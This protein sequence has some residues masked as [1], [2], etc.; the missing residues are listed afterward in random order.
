MLSEQKI[1]SDKE[2]KKILN[3]LLKVD[4]LAIENPSL[5]VYLPYEAQLI[6]EIG[7]VGGKMHIGRSRNDLDNTINRMYLR[8]QLLEVIGAVNKLRIAIHNKA[9]D[10]LQNVMVIYT[11]RKEAQPGTLGHYLMAIDESLAKS[12][13]RYLQL[14]ER[15]DQ[16]PLG[17][18]ASGGTSWNLDRYRAAELM[19]FN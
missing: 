18:G 7:S 17:S 13:D 3:G 10:H 9:K 8:D 11:H 12:S 1:I 16:C 2:A 4:K 15:I 5:Q 6:K 14:Y 19:G